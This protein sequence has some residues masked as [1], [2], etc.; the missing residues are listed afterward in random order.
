LG[1]SNTPR[2]LYLQDFR[3]RLKAEIQI[4]G[5]QI[6]LAL[7]PISRIWHNL[8]SNAANA[9]DPVAEA[10]IGELKN[11]ITRGLMRS[12]RLILI[13]YYHVNMTMKEIGATPD[14]SESRVSQMHG[15]VIKRLKVELTNRK[16]LFLALA[17]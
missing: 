3:T 2:L 7:L 5:N 10:Q 1:P 9:P 12:E 4:F 6:F 14:L 16:Q 13:L 11:L 15:A 8:G 17:G